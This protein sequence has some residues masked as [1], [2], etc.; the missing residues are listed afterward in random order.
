MIYIYLLIW[1]IG[2]HFGLYALFKKAGI[3]AWKG[4]VPFLNGY[5]MIQATGL[6]KYW[7][8]LQFIPI[9]GQ[10]ITIW[11]G[12][13]FVMHF[14][15]VSFK[16]HF[17]LCFVPFYYLPFLAHNKNTTWYG[18]DALTHYHKSIAREWADA[19]VFAVIAAT[20]IRTFTFEMYVIP[21]ESMEKTLVV[22]D[23]LVVNKMVY[24]ARIPQTPL[25]F[26]FVHNTLPFS[27]TIPS[28]LTWIQLGYHRLP[29]ISNVQRND[30]VVFNFPAGDTIINLP[31]FGS[32]RPYYDVLREKYNNNRE[33]LFSDFPI[34]VHPIDKTDNYVKRCV[35]IPGDTIFIKDG[36]L[37]VNNALSQFPTGSQTEYIVVTNGTNFSDEFL[38][39][40]LEIDLDEPSLQYNII[41]AAKGEYRFNLTT[42]NLAKLKKA[43]N[44]KSITPFIENTQTITFPFDGIHKNWTIDNFGP[45]IIPQKNTP[46][47][48]DKNNIAIYERMIKVYENNQLE[49]KDSTIFINGKQTNSYTPKYNYY[50]MMGD[51]RHF[52][53]DSRFWGFVPETHIVGR[54]SLIWF[55]YKNGIRWKRM[56]NLI[57]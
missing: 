41:D 18:K 12:I 30:V 43:P 33:A 24:G 45:I 6:K 1:L 9:V 40:D 13:Y 2:W 27:A 34:L 22:N 11:V 57:K 21:T 49:I 39:N 50:W 31:E 8:W 15:K 48:L 47:Y 28:Y 16:D 55:S 25:F 7:F 20:I 54:A 35:A 32:K 23:F 53:Q 38:Q 5:Y 44:V 3:A 10:F 37:Y 4:A 56:F 52:S 46:L 42:E 17:L 36:V 51:N 26:P 14:K 29:I 19:I